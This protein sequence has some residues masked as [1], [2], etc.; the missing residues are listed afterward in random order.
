MSSAV[1]RSFASFG[2]GLNGLVGGV[3]GPPLLLSIV[4]RIPGLGSGTASAG[5][6]ASPVA[7]AG[8]G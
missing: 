8:L 3:A 6:P 4:D 1:G 2:C 7:P 5:T